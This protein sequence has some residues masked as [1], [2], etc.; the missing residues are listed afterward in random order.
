[1]GTA[2]VGRLPRSAERRAGR[3][4]SHQTRGKVSGPGL[5]RSGDA[6]LPGG[7]LAVPDPTALQHLLDAGDRPGRETAGGNRRPRSPLRDAE[8]HQSL[9]AHELLALRGGLRLGRGARHGPE[10][11]ADLRGDGGPPRGTSLPKPCRLV[12]FNDDGTWD[13]FPMFVVSVRDGEGRVLA[14]TLNVAPV[15]TE[16]AC[17]LCHEAESFQASMAA[18]LE[19]HDKKEE[20]G[21]LAQAEAGKPRDV[22]LL[23]CR[24]GDGRHREQGLR[25]DLVGRRCTVSTPR[26][27]PKPK[28]NYR[29][30]SAT[31]VTP[32]RRRT[33]CET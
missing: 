7:L 2:G 28:R 27:W 10:G 31:P 21:L 24:S 13:P 29:R 16:M 8:G 33:V 19:A 22:Q 6:L 5:E 18:I 14:E 15:S 4:A 1:M 11:Q 9:A 30:T 32:A 20:T 3:S 26:S 12:D 17:D 23:P 25:V